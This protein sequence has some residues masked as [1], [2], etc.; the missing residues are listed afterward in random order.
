MHNPNNELVPQ[1]RRLFFKKVLAT[2]IGSVLGLAPVGAGLALLLDPLR[3][4][5]G[6][7]AA[8][9]VTTLEAL[10][11]DGMPHKFPVL[12]TRVDAWNK[13]TQVPIGAV[14]LQRLQDGS[15]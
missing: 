2:L 12:A 3:R 4:K 5:A 15:V 14:Y 11:D 1:D 13:A 9:R 6:G 10:P 8:V 7:G